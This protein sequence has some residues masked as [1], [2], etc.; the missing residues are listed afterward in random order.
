ML[1]GMV[2]LWAGWMGGVGRF[3]IAIEI[4]ARGYSLIEGAGYMD[5]NSAS[6][7]FLEKHV[8]YI[9]KAKKRIN[10]SHN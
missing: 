9:T 8:K 1:C 3:F 6:Q 5:D 7:N 2:V 10:Y 4:P